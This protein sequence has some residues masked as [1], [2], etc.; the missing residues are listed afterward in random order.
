MNDMNWL[1]RVYLAYQV[2]SN[3]YTESD[4]S[5]EKFI[6]YLYQQY[7]IVHPEQRKQYER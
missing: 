4:Q 2:Y 5:V 1:D 6:Q 7:G 3:K